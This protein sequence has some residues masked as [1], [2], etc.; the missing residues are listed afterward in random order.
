MPPN[1]YL[2]LITLYLLGFSTYITW[3]SPATPSPRQLSV[4]AQATLQQEKP[5]NYQSDEITGFTLK[6]LVDNEPSM[7]V[8]AVPTTVY[9]PRSLEALHH[10][11]LRSLHLAESEVVEWDRLDILGPDI[12]DKH[13]LSQLARMAGNAYALPG[14]KNW[15]EV[16]MAWNTV[17]L[18][19]NLGG[20]WH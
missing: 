12:E 11:R 5:S 17:R 10:A 18:R 1:C 2:L 14:Q 15:Y 19:L 6:P 16:D 8:K 7:T 20:F 4:R 3:A 9:R 13:T